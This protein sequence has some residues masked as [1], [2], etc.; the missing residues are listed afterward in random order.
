MKNGSKISELDGHFM[1]INRL[2][3]HEFDTFEI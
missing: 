3:E 1:K 2:Y